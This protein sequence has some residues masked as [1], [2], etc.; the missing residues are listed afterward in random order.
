[1]TAMPARNASIVYDFSL[2]G[3]GVTK[4]DQRESWRAT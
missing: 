3:K 2:P 4:R 1:M